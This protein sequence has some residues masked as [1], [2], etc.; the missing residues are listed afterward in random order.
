MCSSEKKNPLHVSLKV[1]FEGRVQ[2]IEIE[3]E[4]IKEKQ[5]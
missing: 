1:L 4:M 2:R 3:T 5:I